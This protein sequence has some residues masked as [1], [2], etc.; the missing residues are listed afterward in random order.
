M[1][2]L[3]PPAHET[4]NSTE[5]HSPD[6]ILKVFAANELHLTKRAELK[7]IE[8]LGTDLCKRSRSGHS[9]SFGRVFNGSNLV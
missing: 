8:A 7:E 4:K 5:S 9:S 3:H 1:S 2:P 6:D